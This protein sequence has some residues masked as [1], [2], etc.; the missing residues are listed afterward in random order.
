MVDH[1]RSSGRLVTSSDRATVA[2]ADFSCDGP[3]FDSRRPTASELVSTWARSEGEGRRKRDR[4]SRLPQRL[5]IGS[6]VLEH[7]DVAGVGHVGGNEVL[8][9]HY[10]RELLQGQ[11]AGI[12]VAY[13]LVAALECPF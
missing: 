1:S 11:P 10:V 13:E 9:L 7:S 2:V 6:E 8:L 3:G 12:A 5:G 4:F